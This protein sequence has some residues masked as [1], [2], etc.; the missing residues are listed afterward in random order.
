MRAMQG[1][2]NPLPAYGRAELAAPIVHSPGRLGFYR[3][4]LEGSSA[5]P[6]ENQSSGAMSS[7]AWADALAVVPAAAE[8]VAAGEW[9]RVLRLDDL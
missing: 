2:R 5:V 4:R 9:V 6:L 7:M 3:V 1:D 8:R